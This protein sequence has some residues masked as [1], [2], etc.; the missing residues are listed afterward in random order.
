MADRSTTT[1]V[2]GI[3]SG[4]ESPAASTEWM[5]EKRSGGEN[6]AATL[7]S[8]CETLNERSK[9]FYEAVRSD[10][11]TNSTKAEALSSAH[12]G[13]LRFKS[14]K[15]LGEVLET[16][17]S[18]KRRARRAKNGKK[19]QAAMK[20]W[21]SN[22]DQ[23]RENIKDAI[24]GMQESMDRY[25][26]VRR[27]IKRKAD[28]VEQME[29]SPENV[30][31]I[32]S[33]AHKICYTSFAPLDYKVGEPLRLF[34]PPAPQEQQMAVSQ[35]YP[36]AEKHQSS[37]PSST[38]KSG[39]SPKLGPGIDVP[40]DWKLGDPLPGASDA[41]AP[42]QPSSEQQQQLGEDSKTASNS[43]TQ[44]AT[45]DQEPVEEEAEVDFILNPDLDVV[46]DDES[47]EEYS[48]DDW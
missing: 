23:L 10:E 27:P 42:E 13:K 48:E 25:G 28:A 4:V 37:V 22:V 38:V 2:N 15:V 21:Q 11:R 45:A 18:L 20:I 43:K 29:P 7:S 14:A 46:E 47:S 32:C 40:V 16:G 44:G 41:P 39:L 35:L 19:L 3:P 34:K 36:F 17:R 30:A 31:A 8:L 33:Y 9:E 6:G 26:D 12:P 1:A 24:Q 5:S